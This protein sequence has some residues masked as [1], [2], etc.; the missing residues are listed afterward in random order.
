MTT[1]TAMEEGSGAASGLPLSAYPVHHSTDLDLTRDWMRS[2]G[3]RPVR[4][5]QAGR[6]STAITFNIGA[7]G[8]VGLAFDSYGAGT[9]SEVERYPDDPFLVMVPV[10]GEMRI[11]LSRLETITSPDLAAVISPAGPLSIHYGAGA[12]T[13]Q[14]RIDR[15]IVQTRLRKML[16][17]ITPR[18]FDFGPHLDLTRTAS[19]TWRSLLDVVVADLDS[20][21]TLT[22]SP[23]AAASLEYA[24]VDGLLVSHAHTYSDHLDHSAP[25]PRPRTIQRAVNLLHDHCEE[26]L[27]T[28][29]VAEAVGLSSRALQ[30]GFRTHVGS[31]PMAYLRRV[32]LHRI[33]D[34][35]LASDPATANVTSIALDWGMTH[36]GRFAQSYR[37]EFGEAPSDTLR[38]GR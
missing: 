24:I 6:S 19:R 9:V 17:G 15:E 35:L 14:V 29:D 4:L 8:G 37:V 27:S 32:R 22:S 20:G 23:L 7:L 1:S 5:R 18:S 33:R 30:D 34:E 13:L 16:G 2:I 3:D 38:R 21:A 26:P 12:Q 36:L 11:G 25:T 31:T 28:A 10:T